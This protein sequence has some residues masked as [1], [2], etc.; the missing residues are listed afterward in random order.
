L[1]AR[2]G[3]VGEPQRQVLP[4]AALGEA[5]ALHRREGDP[6]DLDRNRLH[7]PRPEDSDALGPGVAERRPTRLDWVVIA[8][9][10]EA[11]DAGVRQAAEAVTKPQLGAKSAL[12]PVVD[13]AGDH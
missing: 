1:Y 2:P 3:P 11:G 5:D 9:H 12:W 6:V 8:V 7:C 13:V 4:F 10:D